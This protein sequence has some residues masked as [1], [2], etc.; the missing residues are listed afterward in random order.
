MPSIQQL[1][2]FIALLAAHDWQFEFSDDH[3]VWKRGNAADQSLRAQAKLN[4]FYARA[5]QS[6]WAIENNMSKIDLH[7]SKRDRLTEI[8]NNLREEITELTVA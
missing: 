5:H 2:A 8:Y 1:N 4:P 6:T 7:L 3:S